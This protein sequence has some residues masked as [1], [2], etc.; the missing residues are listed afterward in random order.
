[1]NAPASFVSDAEVQKAL[2][3]LRDSAAELGKLTEQAVL[4]ERLTKHV[5]AIAMKQ[6]AEASVNAQDREATASSQYLEAI[7]REAI[8][9]GELAKAKALREAAA[10]KLDCWRTQQAT[11]RAYKL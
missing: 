11:Q 7:T 5:K 4:A 10:A 6:C 2:D 8:T 3:F 9:A 1:M